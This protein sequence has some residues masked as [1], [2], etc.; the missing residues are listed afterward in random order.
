MNTQLEPPLPKG[1][2][3]DFQKSQEGGGWRFFFKKGG[4]WQ[5]GGGMPQKGG[6]ANFFHDASK[7]RKIFA[8]GGLTFT[9]I[10]VY[11]YYR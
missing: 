6:M 9:H 11:L 7:N 3:S 2:D 5:K 10:V 4:G 1:G 8:C